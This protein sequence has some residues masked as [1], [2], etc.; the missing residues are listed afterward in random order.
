MT[1]T[2]YFKSPGEILIVFSVSCLFWAL[3]QNKS[4]REPLGVNKAVDTAQ[5]WA[6]VWRG[7]SFFLTPK[8]VFALKNDGGASRAEGSTEK[9]INP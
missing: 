4:N 9:K 8:P 2:F 7:A 5:R 3:G 6:A 1:K